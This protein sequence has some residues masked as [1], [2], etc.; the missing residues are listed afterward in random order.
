M[1]RSVYIDNNF[2]TTI[3][4]IKRKDMYTYSFLKRLFNPSIIL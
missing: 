2:K 4:N 1:E 3:R